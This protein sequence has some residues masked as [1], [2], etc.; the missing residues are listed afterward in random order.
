MGEALK[1]IEVPP[2]LIFRFHHPQI[3]HLEADIPLL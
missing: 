2:A 1:N 3:H